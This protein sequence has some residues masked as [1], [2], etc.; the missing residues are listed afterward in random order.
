MPCD[1][2]KSE[3]EECRIMRERDAERYAR[4]HAEEE[5]GGWV[6]N[7][8]SSGAFFDGADLAHL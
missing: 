7:G 5:G 4:M 2:H 8:V 6:Y 1:C 3:H